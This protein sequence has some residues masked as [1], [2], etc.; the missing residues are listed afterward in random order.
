MWLA[1]GCTLASELGLEYSSC[2][3]RFSLGFFSLN[4]FL[5]LP[6][7]PFMLAR[8]TAQD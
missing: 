2:D 1:Q 5:Q 8:T 3:P 4:S 7:P 6:H